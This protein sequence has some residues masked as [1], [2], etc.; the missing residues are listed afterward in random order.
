VASVFLPDAGTAGH[1][2]ASQWQ[3]GDVVLV[4]DS[5]GVHLER[6]IEVLLNGPLFQ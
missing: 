6:T 4:K 1:W 3:P 5:R 2:L